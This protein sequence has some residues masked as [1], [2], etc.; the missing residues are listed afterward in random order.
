VAGDPRRTIAENALAD[1]RPQPVG[2]EQGA[3]LHPLAIVEGNADA[4]AVLLEI[5]HAPARLE[6]DQVAVAG[7]LEDGAVDV[8]AMRHRVRLA[9]AGREHVRVERHA[10]DEMA[11]EGVAH[12]EGARLPGVR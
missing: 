10:G 11:V 3:A 8:G 12:L 9:E 4:A 1:A 2:A 7:G 5:D 6:A